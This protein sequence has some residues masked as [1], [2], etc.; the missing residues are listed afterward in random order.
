MTGSGLDGTRARAMR[1]YG[2]RLLRCTRILGLRRG[3]RALALLGV[4][5]GFGGSTIR[6]VSQQRTTTGAVSGSLVG[7]WR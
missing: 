3:G 7:N 5:M 2:M 4:T 1:P 6:V